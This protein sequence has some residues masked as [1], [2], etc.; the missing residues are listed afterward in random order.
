MESQKGDECEEYSLNPADWNLLRKFMQKSLSSDIDVTAVVPSGFTW[1]GKDEEMLEIFF[2]WYLKSIE[3]L[4]L[5][6]LEIFCCFW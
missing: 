1:A 3:D 2:P 6:N 4:G 5:T